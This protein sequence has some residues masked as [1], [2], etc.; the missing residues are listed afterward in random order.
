[1]ALEDLNCQKIFAGRSQHLAAVL[2]DGHHVLDPHAPF[3]GEV[4]SRLDGDDHARLEH[5]R[6]PGSNSRRFVDL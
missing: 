6:L 3:A 1:M 4:Y 5:F 2:A